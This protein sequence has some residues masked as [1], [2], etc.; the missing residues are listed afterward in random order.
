[1]AGVFLL[2]EPL[3]ISVVA[4]D[5]C[6]TAGRPL[7]ESPGSWG[8]LLRRGLDVRLSVLCPNP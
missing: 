1:M 2:L 7:L 3:M 6:P 5:A 4:E 8:W